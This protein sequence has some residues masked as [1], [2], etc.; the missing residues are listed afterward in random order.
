M[1]PNT[2]HYP[3]ELD[4]EYSRIHVGVAWP[5]ARPGWSVVVGEHRR[6]QVAGQPRLDVLDEASDPRLWHVVRQ[7][8]G[9]WSY[10]RPE[11]IWADFGHRA[12]LQFVHELTAEQLVRAAD[13]R[14]PWSETFLVSLPHPC[15]Y[16]LPVLDRLLTGGR[17]ILP[18][19]SDLQG[20]RLVPPA[21]A[22]P[23]TLLLSDYPAL[24]ALGCAVLGLEQ[25]R[26]AASAAATALK[27]RQWK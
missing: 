22:D 27:L 25:S 23:A 1:I 11:E 16:L 6:V 9:F 26:P 4:A 15:A 17:L 20:E 2:A 5:A 12:A 8:G 21:H 13:W 19:A 18:D 14:F 3:A 10:Y 24:A 7:A